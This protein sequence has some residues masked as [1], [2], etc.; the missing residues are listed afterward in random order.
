MLGSWNVTRVRVAVRL[1]NLG[2]RARTVEV[3]ERVPVSEIDKVEIQV[4]AADAWRLE[5]DDGKRADDV[6]V[7]TARAV[8]DDGL[9]TWKVELPSRARRAVAL[10]YRLRAHTSVVGV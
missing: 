10:E 1:S 9:A 8:D 3:T 4:A 2:E 5:D 6:E 7:V